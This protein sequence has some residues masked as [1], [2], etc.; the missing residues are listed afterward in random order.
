MNLGANTQ[1][2]ASV[3]AFKLFLNIFPELMEYTISGR[4]F[5]KTTL[6]HAEFVLY[7]TDKN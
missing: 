6:F 4:V 2:M 3:Q 7:T 1:S 5:L